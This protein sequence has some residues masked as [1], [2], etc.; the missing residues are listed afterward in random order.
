MSEA[1]E[2]LDVSDVTIPTYIAATCPNC[3]ESTRFELDTDADSTEYEAVYSCGERP[4]NHRIR[5]QMA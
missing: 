3:R 5:L 2:L 4:C 1:D